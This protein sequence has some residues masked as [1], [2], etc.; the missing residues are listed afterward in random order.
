MSQRTFSLRYFKVLCDHQKCCVN[1]YQKVEN[2][3]KKW[4]FHVNAFIQLV[5]ILNLGL[6]YIRV[7]MLYQNTFCCQWKL[8]NVLNR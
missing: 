7:K 1:H 6:H 3:K 8:S 5:S 2:E 4:T